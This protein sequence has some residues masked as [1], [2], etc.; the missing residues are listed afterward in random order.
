MIV[1]RTLRACSQRSHSPVREAVERRLP[2]RHF[3]CAAPA[4]SPTAWGSHPSRW[5]RAGPDREGRWP[6]GS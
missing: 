1:E 2:W 6:R 3:V 5:R 4:S